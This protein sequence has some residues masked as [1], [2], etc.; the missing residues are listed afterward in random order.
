[1]IEAKVRYLDGIQFVGESSSGH[2]VFMHGDNEGG[3]KSAGLMPDDLLLISLG[4]CLG[5]AAISVLKEKKQNITG[6]EVI[7]RGEK[8]DEWPKRFTTITVEF[9]VT[10]NKLSKD[11]VKK[12]IKFST[13]K[14]STVRA[15]LEVFPEMNF[16]YRIAEASA[17]PKA[18]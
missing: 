4:S 8:E 1:M 15:T 18:F 13:E 3:G 16:G 6:L 2:V 5:T 12:A 17:A 9:L 14:Y 7:V 11:A 10:G